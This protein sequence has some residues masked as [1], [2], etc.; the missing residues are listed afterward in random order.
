MDTGKALPE[1]KF[2][3]YISKLGAWALAIGTAI[4]WGSFVVMSNSYLAEAGPLGSGIGLIIGAVI[5]VVI[6]KNYHYMINCFP[7]AGGAYAY[8]KEAFGYDHGFLTAWFLGLTYFAMFWANAT[9][10]PLFARYFF[11]DIFRFGKLYTIFGYE[12]YLGEILLTIAAIFLI[13]LLCSKCR[14]ALNVIMIVLALLFTAGIVITF[15]AAMAGHGSTAFSFAPGF[16]PNKKELM[17][18]VRIAAISP[19]AFI[20]FESISHSA[21]EFTFQRSKVFRILVTAIVSVTALYIFVMLLSVSAY[22]AEYGSWLEYLKDLGNL[23]GI[24][25]LPAFYA[26]HHYLGNF[27]VALLIAVLLAL[28]VTSLIANIVALSRLLYKMAEDSIL[29]KSLAILNKNHIPARAILAIAVISAV[30]PF[31]G[32]TAIG[33]IVDVTTIGA[34]LIYGYVS[35]SARKIARIRKDKNE[36]ITGTIGLILMIL[37]AAYL[38]IPNLFSAGE[39]AKETYFL[40]I[41]WGVLGFIVF[42][43]ILK[44]DSKRNFGKSIVVWI[45]LISMILFVSLIWMN[46]S[47]ISSASKAMTTINEHYI[48]EG[49][50]SDARAED[51]QFMEEQVAQME[52]ANTTTTLA[53]TGFFALSLVILLTN[54][55]YVNKRALQNEEALGAARALANRDPLTGVK[56]KHAYAEAEEKMNAEIAAGGAE[57]F[58]IAVC[59]VNGLKYINDTYGHKAGDEYIKK[60]CMMVCEIFQHSPVYRIGGDEFVVIMHGPDFEHREALMMELH[61]QSAAHIGSEDVVVAGGLSDFIPEEDPD[62]RAVFDRADARMYEEKQAL[63]KMGAKTR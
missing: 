26:A 43:M 3:P 36:I 37:F 25:G 62:V 60:A 22:P 12:V 34:T 35:A 54:F 17:Q 48:E 49:D 21:E 4:G 28:I 33:W 1:E 38:L 47:M 18:I 11:G 15:A 2:S 20:G 45:A 8:S 10:L 30:I 50:L 52:R 16:T 6:S 58:S 61:D 44:R 7:D 23:S 55:A 63:K 59:D 56:S 14:K 9:S 51:E 31:F 5:M 13:A 19:W 41:I 40:L 53:V 27:G 42:R 29:P 39:M 24:E 32:R 57:I 46:Q